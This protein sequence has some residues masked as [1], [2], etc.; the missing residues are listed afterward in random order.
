MII[1]ADDNNTNIMHRSR[2][3]RP[4]PHLHL[5]IKVVWDTCQYEYGYSDKST[6]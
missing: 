4:P 3:G 2:G 6:L 1:K 5:L